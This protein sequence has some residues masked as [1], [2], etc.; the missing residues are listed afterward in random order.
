MESPREI[1][2]LIEA[3]E[4]GRFVGAAGQAGDSGVRVRPRGSANSRDTV[5]DAA[6]RSPACGTEKNT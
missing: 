6:A 4:A 5:F 2:G 3:V 1:R